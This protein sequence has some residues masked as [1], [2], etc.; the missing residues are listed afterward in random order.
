MSLR[1]SVNHAESRKRPRKLP[2]I[3]LVVL[4]LG[5]SLVT[6]GVT[7]LLFAHV[8][9]PTSTMGYIKGVYYSNWSVYGPKHFPSHLDAD[10]LTHVFYAFLKVDAET[11]AAL[12]TD[13]WADVEMPVDGKSGAVGALN[14]LREQNPKLS[15]VAS[16]GGWGTAAMFQVLAG[17][18]RK[19]LQFISTAL[20]LVTTHKFNGLDIDW[21]Y[22]SSPDEGQQLAEL[23]RELRHAMDN[24]DR[25]LILTVASPSSQEH[26]ANYPLGRMDRYL[27]FWNVMCYDFSGQG[28]SEKT[29]HHANLYGDNGNNGLS[30]S[31]AISFYI[32]K[33][34]PPSKLVLGMPLY[35]RTFYEPQ[36]L[37]IGVPFNKSTPYESDIVDYIH[38]T[39]ENEVFDELRVGALKFDPSKKLL[40]SYDN[41]Q[42]VREKARYVARNGLG[43]GFWWDSKGEAQSQQRRLIRAFAQELDRE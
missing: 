10:H 17:D 25:S 15:I 20:D 22:P 35:A 31:T 3:L 5:F 11:G 41:P 30:A 8:R 28:W 7:V 29:G 21:E 24:V 43:G 36:S 37:R 33:G 42:C 13:P 6:L 1:L 27:S 14:N 2:Q 26:L 12:F 23:L 16:V 34:I 32:Q 19:R 40:Y 9:T 18:R 38:I 4:L 39:D